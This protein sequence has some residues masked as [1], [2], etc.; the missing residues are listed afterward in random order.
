MKIL[1]AAA[2]ALLLQT[3]ISTVAQAQALNN[4]PLSDIRVRQAIAH[5]IDRN[6]IVESVFGGYAVP[7]IGMLPNGPFKSPNLNAYEYDPDKARALLAEAGW[8]NG[9]SL[10][11]VYYYDDQITADLMSVIQAQLGDVGINMTYNLIVG[12]VAKTLN[13]IPA[14]P[15]GKSVVNWDM[16]YGARAAM[17]MQEYFNDYATGKA[18]ADGFPGSPELDA[19]ILESNTA[20]DPEVAKA[21][22]M[23]IDEYINANMLTLPL[24][25]QQLMSVESDRL[26]R[27]GGPYGNDQ[28]NYDWDVHA[29]TVTPDANGKHILYTNG[30]P[31]D[32]FENPWVNLGLWAGNKFIWAHMLGAKPFLDG[33]TSGDIAEAYEMSEDGKTLTFTLREGMK[34]HDGE[35][36]TVDDV[37]FSLAYAL[38]TPN[39]HGI[40][41]SVLNGMEGAA[42]YVSGAATSVSGI[43]SEGNKITLKFTAPNANTLIAF[44]QW[45]P[46]PKKYFENV[47]PTL[48]QQSEF[49]QKPVG[50]GPFKVE[51]AKFGD[52]SSFVPFDDY[53]EGKPKIDQIIAW[54]SADGDVNMVK[55]AAANRIDFAVTKV[56]SDIEAIKALPHMRMTPLDIPYTR[57]LWFQMYDQ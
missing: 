14:D 6:L 38:K 15:K 18:S 23:K 20:T 42:D 37:T 53:Y 32:Y 54:A 16:A 25:Y 43:S 48:V 57:M 2:V 41:A 47:D 22:L 9:D 34:W 45:G 12:D 39:L 24:Y 36:I 50:S 52:F 17:V 29:W 33:I 3:G 56:V 55:N 4:N 28:F 44:T 19:L 51:E 5:A 31:F 11:F 40:V 10:E 46:F 7:A 27:N 35:P 49:W 8:K 30:A 1:T 21:T 26:N 13:S